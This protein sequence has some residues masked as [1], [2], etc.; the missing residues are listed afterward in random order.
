VRADSRVGVLVGDGWEVRI[1]PRLAI[2]RLMFLLAYAADQRGWKDVV[3]PFEQ[4]SDEVAAV[5][6]GFSWH[7]SR[8]LERGPIRGYERRDE[9]RDG[10]R[11]RVR[12]ADQIARGAG[13]PVPLE[14]TYSDYTPDVLE[15]RMLVTAASLLLRMPRVATLA[16]RRLLHVRSGLEGVRMLRDWRGIEAPAV[17]RL[18]EHYRP[19]IA[20]AALVLRHLSLATEAGGVSSTTFVFDMNQVFE[21]FVTA[22]FAES[23]RRHGGVVRP[24]VGDYS[25]DRAGRLRLKPDI[26]WWSGDRCLAVLDAKYKAIDDGVLRHGDAYQMLAYCTAYGLKRGYLVYAKDTG[27]EA[28]THVVRNAETEIVVTPLDVEAEPEALLGHVAALADTVAAWVG[29]QAAA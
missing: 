22:A 11:G 9:R 14:V 26:G 23:M 15:N 2:P 1:R 3:A 8:A 25:L 20:L 6:S 12:F 18:N 5:A 7:A 10:L 21:D 17:T 29:G 13:L 28:T 19:A 27:T 4:E 24:Q 16:R